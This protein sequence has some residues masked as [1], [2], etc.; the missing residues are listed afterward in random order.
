MV[1]EENGPSDSSDLRL[2]GS[3]RPAGATSVQASRSVTMNPE[4]AVTEP[5][6]NGFIGAN[7]IPS[8][9]RLDPIHPVQSLSSLPNNGHPSHIS[10]LSNNNPVSE[11]YALG[12]LRA[13]AMG[14]STD[15]ANIH[16]N[17]LSHALA[18]NVTGHGAKSLA[19]QSYTGTL[20]SIEHDDWLAPTDPSATGLGA[21]AVSARLERNL[22]Q[23]M[24]F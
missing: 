7:S 22:F 13:R 1:F 18:T 20:D 15:L 8:A 9:C 3:G 12:S 23:Q 11:Y 4:F 14:T 19:W 10:S 6:R 17:L 24:P 21:E 2:G 16:E 5:L